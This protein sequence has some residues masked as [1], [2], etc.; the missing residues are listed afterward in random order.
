MPWAMSLRLGDDKLFLGPKQNI[1][2]FFMVYL[3][4]YYYLSVKFV[5]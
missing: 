1:C 2:V 3:I 5:F 4:C